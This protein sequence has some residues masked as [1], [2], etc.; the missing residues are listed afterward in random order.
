[1]LNDPT[2]SHAQI[3]CIYQLLQ[4]PQIDCNSQLMEWVVGGGRW[5]WSGWSG[6]E[7][8][9]CLTRFIDQ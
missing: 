1:M 8:G 7:G 5:E 6:P 4:H 9:M 2:Q 3:D